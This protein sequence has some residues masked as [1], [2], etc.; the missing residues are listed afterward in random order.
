MTEEFLDGADIVAGFQE[1]G[2]EAVAKRMTTGF[3]GQASGFD[4]FLYRLLDA[5][6]MDVMAPKLAAL[7]SCWLGNICGFECLSWAGIDA[8][9][10]IG[11]EVFPLER[12]A[13]FG[14]FSGEG[15]GEPNPT[16][17][18]IEVELMEMLDGL[19][20]LFEVI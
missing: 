10:L 14:I 9:Q 18:E 6:F 19:K 2:C 1:M 3:F 16:G 7:G 11:E 17:S 5:G 15:V 4:C 12:A 13:G 20:L 8:E